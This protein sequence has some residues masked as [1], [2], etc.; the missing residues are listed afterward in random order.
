MRALLL[1]V[2]LALAAP[3]SSLTVSAPILDPSPPILRALELP[4][5]ARALRRAG[6][7]EVEVRVSLDAVR[8]HQV[9]A[10]DLVFVFQEALV[11]TRTYGTVPNFGAFVQSRL[12]RGLRGRALANAIHAEHATYGNGH[13]N[14]EKGWSEG[15]GAFDE[16]HG[17]KH[18]EQHGGKDGWAAN[19]NS[20]GKSGRAGKGKSKG[21]GGKGS[22][23]EKW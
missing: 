3:S 7:E 23:K 16:K 1:L 21:R 15:H 19:G 5:A 22:G 18:V 4:H 10:W 14:D 8:V 11:S 9:H 12:A 13:G 20:N 2:G 17:G 6:V